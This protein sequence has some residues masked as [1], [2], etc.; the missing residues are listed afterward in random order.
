MRLAEHAYPSIMNV[1]Y[2]DAGEGG[3][4]QSLVWSCAYVIYFKS[5]KQRKYGTR[6]RNDLSGR[7]ERRMTLYL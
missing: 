7:G 6:Q 4:S 3:S 5:G 1:T 2:H